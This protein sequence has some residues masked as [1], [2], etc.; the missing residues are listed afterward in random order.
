MARAR[1]RVEINYDGIG[2]LAR[3]SGVRADLERRAQAVRAAA[4]A[5]APRMQEGRIEIEASTRVG[6][7]R[8]RG[9][10]VAQHPGVLHAEAKHRFLGGA[11][12]AAG[13]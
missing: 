12:D 10:V 11:M 13:D 6:R 1:V 2:Q 9:I 3:S 7:D 5:A 8:A 4:Q